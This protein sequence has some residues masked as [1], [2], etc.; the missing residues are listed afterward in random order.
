MKK[1]TMLLVVIAAVIIGFVAG[2]ASNN[3]AKPTAAAP[4]AV[5]AAPADAQAPAAKGDSLFAATSPVKGAKDALVTI[6]EVSDFQCPFCSRVGP[7]IKKLM[8]DYPNDVRV[9]W[10]NQPLPF[11]DR[12][13]P[14]AMAALAAHRQ[15][16]FWEMHDKLFANQR[17]LTDDNLKKFAGE[18]GCDMAKWE[19]DSK[20]DVLVKQ[21]EK[22]IASGNA[23][24]ARGT[25]AFFI[26]GK[27]LS[28][29]Q[30]YEAF[31]KEVD[32]ALAAAK[33]LAATKKGIE[34]MEAA[35]AARD[36]AVG[37]KVVAYFVKGE[38]APAEA[39]A[40]RG[41][42]KPEAHDDGPAK[43]PPDSYDIW[44]V[45]VDVKKDAV[46][47]DSGKAIV[48]I[49]EFSDFQC[50][51]CSR[52]AAT[53]AGLEKEYGDKVRLVF[54]H[55]P[56]P[57]HDN[58]KPASMAAV[59]AGKQGKFW[60]FHDKCFANQG[61]LTDDNLQAW[62]K[63]IGLNVDK[64]N[65]D[66]KSD[67]VAKQIEDDMAMGQSV[68]IRGTP[69]FMINGRKVVGAQ[70]A[71][72]FKAVID[73]EIAK[74]EKAGNK[75]GAA[76]Y[77]EIVSKGKTFSELGDKAAELNL[78]GLPFKGPKDAP[79]T[80]TEFSDFQ[81]PFCSRINDPVKAAMDKYPGKVKV[82]FAHFP[83]GFHQMA[84][85]AATAAQTAWEDSPEKFWKLHEALFANQKDLSEEK[86]D[87]LAKEAGVDM[88]K[89]ADNKKNKKFDPLFDKT[90]EMGTKA[91][92]EG[93]PT[94]LI[95]GRKFEPLAGFT[96]ESIGAAIDKLL[97]K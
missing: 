1:E 86:I 57:F 22:E 16:K 41:E 84:R 47:G 92:V 20:D 21:I 90:T 46:K 51:F 61:T 95:N 88:A 17:E 49:V 34:F 28:G 13:K 36:A 29:A 26:N 40:P 71:P 3:V 14:A 79:I 4:V 19:K 18:I 85:P 59:A 82:V 24:G 74:A 15:G 78:D 80:I 48:T 6:F 9:V 5:A 2:R 97:K 63:E 12:A 66:R 89:L 25:P 52:A 8:E 91:G 60:E 75:K 62:A 35:F 38:A 96:P 58:A 30:P 31:K 73:E 93:T 50:P 7:T 64:F 94:I 44:K 10:V 27:L 87:A 81:C 55:T 68:S 54:K 65:A 76:Y 33:P 69:G 39:A 67:A 53:V 42:E 45:P 83:L 56:L 77:D 43:A 32:E 72:V 11:H 37:A 70:P 23:L